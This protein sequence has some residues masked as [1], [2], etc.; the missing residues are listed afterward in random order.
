[1]KIGLLIIA[2]NRYREFLPSLLS[3]VR[4][5]F[6]K[7]HEVEIFVFSDQPVDDVT[8]IYTEHRPWPWMTLGR[9]ALFKDLP[10]KDYYFYIDADNR[11]QNPI[12]DEILGDRVA[13]EHFGFKGGKGT[14]ETNPSS[15]AYISPEENYTYYWGAFQG[16]K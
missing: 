4:K 8:Y 7:N 14:H 15:I 6:L 9:Y 3:D 2:T 12:G 1:M 11:I 16:G 10:P 5:Y 13:A